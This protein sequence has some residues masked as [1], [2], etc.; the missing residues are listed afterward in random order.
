M[1]VIAWDS[2]KVANDPILSADWNS[3][4]TDQ[5]LRTK[6]EQAW[7]LGSDCSG[8]DGAE[9]RVLTLSNASISSQEKVY[10]DGVLLTRT[11]NYTPSHLAASSTITF[12]LPIHNWRK[13]MVEYY[14]YA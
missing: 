7:K 12:L 5:K 9:N 14:V 10:L 3:M 8:S 13:I 4:I 2:V 11:T 6:V 1:I